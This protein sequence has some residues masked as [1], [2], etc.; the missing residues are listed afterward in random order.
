VLIKKILGTGKP[1]GK[2][3]FPLPS[4]LFPIRIFALSAFFYYSWA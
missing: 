2:S 3:L 1:G 4:S